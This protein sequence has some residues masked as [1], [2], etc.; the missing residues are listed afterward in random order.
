M[1]TKFGEIYEI[2]DDP[3]RVDYPLVASWLAQ[4]YWSP[5]ISL[6]RVE[7]AAKNS[8]LIIGCYH[9]Q[10]QAGY[11]RVVSDRARFA[12]LLDVIVDEPH[13]GKGIGRQM[14]RLALENPEFANVDFW[15]L[16]TL[17]AHG[18]YSRLGFAPLPEPERWMIRR[19]PELS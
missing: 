2:D 5:G 8:S 12:Y 19:R 13:R 10:G 4:T 6:Q 11:M 18:V 17:D 3:A 7:L 15:I 1:K 14:V 16:A 9:T